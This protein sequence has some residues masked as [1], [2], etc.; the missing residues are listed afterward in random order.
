MSAKLDTRVLAALIAWLRS[1]SVRMRVS[2]SHVWTAVFSVF[3]FSSY[4]SCPS[5]STSHCARRSDSGAESAY[6]SSRHTV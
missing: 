6:T 3:H 1:C 2:S 5:V 4:L